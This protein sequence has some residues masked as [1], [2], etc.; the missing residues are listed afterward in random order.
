MT[1]ENKPP[2]FG[3]SAMLDPSTHEPRP[4]KSALMNELMADTIIGN[5]TTTLPMKFKFDP[6][7]NGHTVMLGTTRNGM[8]AMFEGLQDQ[9][10][11]AGGAVQVVDKGPTAER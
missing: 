8:S 7:D 10:A 3:P 5:C 4:G 1:T 11:K 2:M 9:Y 6:K